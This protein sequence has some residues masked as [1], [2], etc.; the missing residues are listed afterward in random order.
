M[1]DWK[2]K[3]TLYFFILFY[4][5]FE[6]SMKKCTCFLFSTPNFITQVKGKRR[7]NKKLDSTT[8]G[9]QHNFLTIID[10][11]KLFASI[12]ITPSL[13]TLSLDF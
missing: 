2:H 5:I 12:K 10:I 4:F 3:S 6:T 13:D 9:I 7:T 8:S 11:A 1:N